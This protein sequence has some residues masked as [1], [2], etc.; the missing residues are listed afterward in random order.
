MLNNKMP[1]GDIS[2]TGI[3]MEHVDTVKVFETEQRITIAASDNEESWLGPMLGELPITL[4]GKMTDNTLYCVIELDLTESMGQVV[5]IEFGEDIKQDIAKT[6]TSTI[7][8]TLGGFDLSDQEGSINIELID[9]IYTLS[10]NGFKLIEDEDTT[11]FGNIVIKDIIIT[12]SD[13][14]KSFET[15]QNIT[16]TATDENVEWVGP[17]LG[18]L[19]VSV[20]GEI[21]RNKLSCA[22]ELDITETWG[23]KLNIVFGDNITD[24]SEKEPDFTRNYTDNLVID[25]NGE[26]TEPQEATIIVEN[27]NGVY[28]LSLNRFAL[29]DMLIG[30][31]CNAVAELEKLEYPTPTRIACQKQQKSKG[32]VYT[33]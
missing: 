12:E 10:L 32:H 8:T 27:K 1:I 23:M 2:I 4:K 21:Y 5:K 16:V 13:G 20:K 30:D 18:E 14:I 25:I 11:Y 19:P 26:T 31:I 3:T 17:E 15:R 7:K 28:T 6:Y 29:D 22:I 33:H 9:S 24:D